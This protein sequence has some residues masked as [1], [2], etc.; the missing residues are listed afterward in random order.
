MTI[1]CLYITIPLLIIFIT[2][3]INRLISNDPKGKIVNKWYKDRS[4]VGISY[5]EQD[6]E[7]SYDD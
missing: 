1:N 5:H 7:S 4:E 6:V 2:L 3:V